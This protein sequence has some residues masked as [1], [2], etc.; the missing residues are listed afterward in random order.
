MNSEVNY[1][2]NVIMQGI[3]FNQRPTS[4]ARWATPNMVNSC[5]VGSI[6]A[7]SLWFPQPHLLGVCCSSSV[8]SRAFCPVFSSRV[9]HNANLQEVTSLNSSPYRQPHL[10]SSTTVVYGYSGRS[11]HAPFNELGWGH[12]RTNLGFGVF[13][14][15]PPVGAYLRTTSCIGKIFP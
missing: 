14:F 5:S 10:V 7:R 9:K 6:S 8:P 1:N 2:Y 4:I 3:N 13:W 11:V 15:I 12:L